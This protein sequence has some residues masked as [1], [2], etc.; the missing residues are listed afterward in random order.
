MNAVIFKYIYEYNIYEYS[1]LKL[2]SFL[3][4]RDPNKVKRT[5]TCM[6]W[7]PGGCRKL[8]VAYSCLD[9]QKATKDMSFDSYIWDIGRCSD[10]S[11]LVLVGGISP[12]LKH[13]QHGF[14]FPLH[15]PEGIPNGMC[16]NSLEVGLDVSAKL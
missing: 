14:N 11:W 15:R 10:R 12:L 6:S 1:L 7:Q 8:A 2:L 4:L 16:V 13:R 9:F 5:V 3:P